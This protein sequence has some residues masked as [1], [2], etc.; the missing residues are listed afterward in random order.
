MEYR[1]NAMIYC[2]KELNQSNDRLTISLQA[3]YNDYTF[4]IINHRNGEVLL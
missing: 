4:V 1:K 2:K 3:R